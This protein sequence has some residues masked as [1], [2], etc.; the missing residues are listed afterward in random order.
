MNTVLTDSLTFES[1]CTLEPQLRILALAC[2]HYWLSQRSDREVE[3]AWFLQFKPEMSKLVGDC[4]NCSALRSPQVYDLCY[5]YLY[6][7]LTTGEV[8]K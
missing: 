7:V 3:R 4:A 8:I 2:R 6:D 5:Q 1:L